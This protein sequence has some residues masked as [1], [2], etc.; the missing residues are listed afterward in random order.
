MYL[1]QILTK[2]QYNVASDRRRQGGRRS[3][4]TVGPPL[5]NDLAI[6][7][8]FGTWNVRGISDKEYD[9]VSV[10]RER[11]LDVLSVSETKRKGKD[12]CELDGDCLALWSGVDSTDHGSQGVGLILSGKAKKHVR[13]YELVSP[14]LLWVRM[15]VG[16]IRVVIVSCYAPVDAE[17]DEVKDEF[18]GQLDRVLRACDSGERVIVLGDLNGWV[19]VK[20]A[21]VEDVIGRFGDPKVNETGER[22]I[23]MCLEHELFV[24]NTCFKHKLKHM[25]TWSRGEQVSMIDYVLYDRRLRD[26]VKDTRVFRGAECGSDHYLVVSRVDLGRKWVVKKRECVKQV[27]VKIERFQEVE[28]RGE[29]AKRL[30]EKLSGV[31]EEWQK[32]VIDEKDVEW[33][34]KLLKETCVNCATEVCGVA[35][36]GRKGGDAWW[37]EEVKKAV[38]EKKKAYLEMIAA[39]N[40]DERKVL[41]ELYKVKREG[42]KQAVRKS[43]EDARCMAEEKMQR[44]FESNKKLY[45][46]LVN[47]VRKG[48]VQNACGVKN[49]E[50]EIMWDENEGRECWR[51]YFM[52]LFVESDEENERINEPVSESMDDNESESEQNV[53]VQE[54]ISMKE[55]LEAVGKLKNGKSPGVDGVMSEMLKYASPMLHVCMLDLFNVC[56]ES[57]KVPDDWKNA[58][59]VP[60]YKGKGDKYECKNHRGISLLSIPG[61]LY[62]RLLIGRVQRV[63]QGKI[64]EVQCG[65]MPGRGCVDQIFTVQQVIEKCAAVNKKMYVAFVD[66]EKAYDKVNRSELWKVLNEYGVQGRLLSAVKSMYDGSKA[67]VRVNNVLSEWFEVKRGVRQGCV[68]SPWLFNIFMDKCVRM[69]IR[70][71][72][73][74]KIG[75]LLL[76]LLLYADDAMLLAES[77]EEL[78]SMLDCLEESTKSMDLKIN[79]GKTKIMVFGGGDEV[80]EIEC[81]LNGEKLERVN[82]FVYLGRMFSEKGSIDSEIDRRVNA[83]RKIVGSMAGLAKS[84]ALSNKAKLAVYNSVLLP[85]LLY[86]SESWVCQ[87]KHKSKLN[88]VGMSFLRNMCGKTRMDRVE[89]TWVMNECGVKEKITDKYERSTLRWF[90]HVVRMG[91]E[92]IAKQVFKGRVEGKRDRGRPKKVWLDGIEDCLKSKNVKS[93]RN[94]RSCVRQRMNV[95]EASEV[96]KD[97]R[98]WKSIVKS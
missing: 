5:V 66:L 10:M 70:G 77:V 7:W 72:R 55:F 81:S 31:R 58:V 2:K 57:S 38:E 6:T 79:V 30:N 34:H 18:W 53:D 75:E 97:R 52:E 61:K 21:G 27:R 86:G 78:Q 20:R 95:A 46:K 59:I 89:N 74:I 28:V 35:I 22:I 25:Y 26:M 32:R 92:R 73:G 84:E 65:F 68:M 88:A 76:W 60:L 64:W 36:V 13:K 39:K 83:G 8:I 15:K 19:G 93:T 4:K 42:S 63:T 24:S 44:E 33:G 11:K 40:E 69:A 87:A 80:D 49:A 43:K 62:A 41:Y 54:R 71:E 51:K 82:E 37:N 91:E 3:L 47:R 17:S 56:V 12:V 1:Y 9:L 94:K 96:C 14:R 90:G 23:N 50:G 98:M 16:V 85:T 29:Y 45:W 48:G 67:C